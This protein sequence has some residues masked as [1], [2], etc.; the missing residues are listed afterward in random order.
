[1]HFLFLESLTGIELFEDETID[2]AKKKLIEYLKNGAINWEDIIMS[3]KFT[4]TND[5]GIIESKWSD[6]WLFGKDAVA[7]NADC[8]DDRNRR[9]LQIIPPTQ[10]RLLPVIRRKEVAWE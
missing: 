6:D 2:A 5:N 10:T 8:S 3:S 1:M 7:A 9:L 4:I